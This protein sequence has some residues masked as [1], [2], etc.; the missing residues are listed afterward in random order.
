MFNTHFYILIVVVQEHIIEIV[1]AGRCLVLP[2]QFAH[3]SVP[4]RIGDRLVLAVF[5]VTPALPDNPGTVL[6]LLIQQFQNLLITGTGDILVFE[7]IVKTQLI[8][9][10]F[11]I[12]IEQA[13]CPFPAAQPDIID[14]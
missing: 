3:S 13:L 10:V 1:S 9:A 8:Q 6:V 7:C 11:V 4:V 5:P 12:E 14:A 2:D